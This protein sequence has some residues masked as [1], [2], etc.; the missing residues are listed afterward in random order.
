[1]ENIVIVAIIG[2]LG[3]LVA[4]FA[5][6]LSR[7]GFTGGLF[8]TLAMGTEQPKAKRLSHQFTESEEEALRVTI[9]NVQNR[10]HSMSSEHI[11]AVVER[12]LTA[13]GY[14]DFVHMWDA[15]I[16]QTWQ[17]VLEGRITH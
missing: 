16:W 10:N 6:L 9:R 4:A 2:A 11:R 17:L 14:V 7:L 12:G 5:L 13:T 1:M 15:D 8:G 3:V